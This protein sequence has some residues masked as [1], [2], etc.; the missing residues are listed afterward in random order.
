MEK[1]AE[2]ERDFAAEPVSERAK[3]QRTHG[4]HRQRQNECVDDGSFAGVE[5]YCE[6]T[7]EKDNY[8]KI[9]CIKKPSEDAGGYCEGPSPCPDVA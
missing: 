5:V 4:P 1:N 2:D 7:E 6:R 9:E 3:D 8:E